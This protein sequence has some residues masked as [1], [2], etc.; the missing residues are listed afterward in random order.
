MR[1]KWKAFGI[2]IGITLIFIATLFIH[3]LLLVKELPHPGWSRSIPLQ[4][5][6]EEKPQVFVDSEDRVHIAANGQVQT[7]KLNDGLT[8]SDEEIMKTKITRGFPFWSDGDQF[9]Y[10]KE[11]NLVS[12]IDRQ[13]QVLEEGIT[14]L[15]TG[16]HDVYFWNDGTLSLYDT[17][18]K[19]SIDLH[20]FSSV[21]S[22]M[23]VAND[24]S[25]IIQVEKDNTHDLLYYLDEKKQVSEP[26]L[27]VDSSPNKKIDGLTFKVKDGNLI[28]FYNEK[29]R[30]QGTLA[31]NVF[32]IIAPVQDI[33]SSMLT[34]E[35]V[36]FVHSQTGQK[37]MSPGGAQLM[38]ID[39]KEMIV[40]T[41]EGTRVGDNN[42][43]SLY[44]APFKKGSSFSAAPVS[45]T[46]HVSYPPVKISDEAMVWMN[47]D[48][49]TYKLTGNSMNPEVIA[50]ST[51]WSKSS[52]KEAFNNGVL[53]MFSSL[54]TIMTSFYW[55]L[56][57]LFL[58]ILMYIFKPN[59]FEKDGISWVEYLA[60][61]IFM[62]MP[63]SYTQNAM[64]AY[65]HVMAP[66]YLVFPGSAY[67]VTIFLSVITLVIWKY[68]RDPD[69]GSMS[70]AFYYMGMY[71]LFYI[72]FIGPYIFNLY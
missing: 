9:I 25:A 22:E 15:G 48:G 13:D 50:E 61:I 47:Y 54:V 7:M 72:T 30:T 68:G 26:F 24:G 8:T 70:G 40:L 51:N 32:K 12:T 71:M 59:A 10:Y 18:K 57:S 42:S 38:T 46:K 23:H 43:I 17:E 31:Y 6:F 11:G 5:S 19:V 1:E 14:G 55:V 49:D 53:M 37:L 28:V 27:T 64:N 58:L 62:F 2:P 60:I 66:G 39:G 69:W 67:A 63:I 36:E 16:K 21:I 35:K 4:A 41:S 45:T 20:T 44:A 3:Q 34:G 65:F 29:S 52:V 33:G 56:P